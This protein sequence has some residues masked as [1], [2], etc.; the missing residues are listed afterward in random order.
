MRDPQGGRPGHRLSLLVYWHDMWLPHSRYLLQRIDEW[1]EVAEIALAGPEKREGAAAIFQVPVDDEGGL[2]RAHQVRTRSYGWRKTVC[3]FREWRRLI[4][5]ERPDVLI[6]CDEA[7]SVNAVLAGLANRLDGK[8]TVLFYGFENIVQGVGWKEFCARPGVSTLR[9]LVRKS[10]RL[11][12]FDRLLMPVRRRVVHGGLVS[13]AECAQV[14]KAWGWSPP[15]L[16]QWWPIDDRC[17]VPDGPRA[18]FDLATP[19]IVGFVGRFVPEKGITDLLDAMGQLDSRY[20]LVLIGDG[21]AR[22]EMQLQIQRLGLTQRARILPPQNARGLAASYRAMNL[23]VL[24]SRPS[25]FWKEQFGRV[26]MEARACGVRI[27]GSD[28]GAIP[29]VVGDPEMIFPSGDPAA[30]AATIRRAAARTDEPNTSARA[31]SAL[32]FMRSW[33][34]LAEICRG[35]QPLVGSSDRA[36]KLS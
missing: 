8:G 26:L 5:S 16:Q 14:V 18:E 35:D 13:Y 31:D 25:S 3:T 6:V 32:E 23:L 28:S 2:R 4:R 34:R 36:P 12:V 24:P 19:Y 15:M 33:L 11:V 7:L 21:P 1:G 22:V 29:A 17:F 20:G 9:T 30:I 10:V 27:A